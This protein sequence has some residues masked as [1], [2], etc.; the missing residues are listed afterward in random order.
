MLWW[1]CVKWD[2]FPVDGMMWLDDGMLEGERPSF[3]IERWGIFAGVNSNWGIYAGGSL[4]H[5]FWLVRIWRLNHVSWLVRAESCTL[6]GQNMMTGNKWAEPW[7]VIGQNLMT[8]NK[9]AEP[10]VV[11]GQNLRTE[12]MSWAMSCD[13]SELDEWI[14]QAD[15]P[16]PHGWKLNPDWLILIMYL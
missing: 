4:N 6:I 3:Y 2:I 10:W 15:W 12:N 8:E 7:V 5:V 13:W 11:I 16:Q 1:V 14:L 9:W